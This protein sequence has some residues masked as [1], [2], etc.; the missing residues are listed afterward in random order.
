MP[1]RVRIS[2]FRMFIFVPFRS[3]VNTYLRLGPPRSYA[4]SHRSVKRDVFIKMSKP[5]RVRYATQTLLPLHLSFWRTTL[6]NEASGSEASG[7]VFF[8]LRIVTIDP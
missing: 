4:P 1:T 7:S 8:A 3:L 6:K 2:D 5:R